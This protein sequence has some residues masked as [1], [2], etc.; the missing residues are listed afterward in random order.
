MV[1]LCRLKASPSL[2]V[3]CG[4]LQSHLHRIYN[5][6]IAFQESAVPA[7]TKQLRWDGLQSSMTCFYR[8]SNS[9]TWT[10]ELATLIV[11]EGVNGYAACWR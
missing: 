10:R 3:T 11:S 5:G 4:K 6:F 7:F 1:L 9:G 8:L 2:F